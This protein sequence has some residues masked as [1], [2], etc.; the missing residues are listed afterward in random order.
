[1]RGTAL[2][3][4]V[5]RLVPAPHWPSVRGR[6]RADAGPLLL[7]ATIVAVVTLLAGAVPPL[8]GATAD[9][10]VQDAV[11]RAGGDADVLVRTDWEPD[12]G[13]TGGRV[14]MPHLAEDV[15][16]FRDRASDALGPDLGAA[17]QR[18]V[19]VVTSPVLNVTDGGVLRTFQLTY[20]AG[21]AGGPGVTWITGGPP[22]STPIDPD[23]S[24]ELPFNAPPWPV[25]VGLSEA[26]AAALGLRTGDHIQLKDTQ[27]QVK[28]VRVSGVFR[29]A[30]DADPVW[31]L[32]PALLRPVP[33]ADGAGTMRTAGLLSRESLSD[34]RL[35][36][37]AEQLQQTVRFAPQPDALSWA[38]AA[39]L[40]RTVV[41]LKATSGSSGAADGSLRWESQLD[42]VL[43]D[44]LTQVDAASTQASVLLAGILLGTVLVL[45]LAADLLVRRRAAALTAARQ[46]GAGLPDIGAELLLEA[47]AVALLAAAAGLAAARALAPGVSWSWIVPVLVAAAAA[48]PALGV[49]T[50]ARATR[51]RRRP[52]NRA[53][54]RW[55]RDTGRLRRAALETAVLIAAAA[56][57]TALHQ[58]GLAPAGSALPVSA[59][60]VGALAAALVLLRLFP[61]G[62]RLALRR[63]LRSRRPW[64][65]SALP[66]RPRPPAAHCRC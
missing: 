37:D 54:R 51:N 13:P 56:A 26:D 23:R 48:G 59:P 39:G 21:D 46:R 43:H 57:F 38:T 9:D 53:A 15:D 7:A 63:A 34:A 10:A 24:V 16:T 44:A 40:G 28:D 61:A 65:S 33:G 18:P 1:M 30:D 4:A 52:A 19:A 35:A 6:A 60:A 31:R 47:A 29:A 5:R 20:L 45:L 2:R 27:Q 41:E 25:Q 50:A 58:R 49:L 17:L 42:A 32:A 12:D 66:R 22:G 62:A 55:A 14:R 64:P 3:R 8:L 11:H 36:F